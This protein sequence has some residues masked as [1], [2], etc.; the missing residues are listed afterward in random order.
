MIAS[1]KCA[2]SQ[3]AWHTKY[4]AMLPVIR[5]RACFAFRELDAEARDEAVQQVIV[6]TFISFSRLAEQDRS[7]LASP[8]TLAGT[9]TFHSTATRCSRDTLRSGVA[10]AWSAYTTPPQIEHGGKCWSRTLEPR[11]RRW[12]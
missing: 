1:I 12:R 8:T 6:S 9:W 4:L 11:R 7:S 2:K 3:L 5:N 10:F